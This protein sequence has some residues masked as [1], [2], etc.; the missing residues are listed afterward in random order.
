MV[1][2]MKNHLKRLSS[3][4]VFKNVIKTKYPTQMGKLPLA[5]MAQA[6]TES[7][8]T[9]LSKQKETLQ[10]RLLPQKKQKKNTN[11]QQE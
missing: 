1:K 4:P 7:A 10:K 8:L 3:Q 2:G 11:K 9:K 5:Q 6:G